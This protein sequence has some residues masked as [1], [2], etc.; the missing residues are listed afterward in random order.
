MAFLLIYVFGLAG[1]ILSI[2]GQRT[3]NKTLIYVSIAPVAFCLLFLVVYRDMFI[4]MISNGEIEGFILASFIV[5]PAIFWVMFLQKID[6][7]QGAPVTNDYLDE[8]IN[9]EDEFE[10]EEYD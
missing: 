2:I 6:I 10:E 8:I 7:K 9:S 1:I 4:S 3:K 5:I